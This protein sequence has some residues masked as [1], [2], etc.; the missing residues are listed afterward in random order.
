MQPEFRQ[1]DMVTSKQKVTYYQI[2]AQYIRVQ[3]GTTRHGAARHSKARHDTAK[4]STAQNSTVHYSTI[5]Y[6]TVQNS[7][8]AKGICGIMSEAS[9]TA[10]VA[11]FKTAE[12]VV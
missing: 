8:K 5:Q 7:M 4:H 9:K 3:Y 10:H 6:S 11:N 2:V 1:D 12:N